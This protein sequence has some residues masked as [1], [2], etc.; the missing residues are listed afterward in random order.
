MT[1]KKKR[2]GNKNRRLKKKA[3]RAVGKFF[4]ILS[5]KSKRPALLFPPNTQH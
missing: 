5:L 4:L 2:R 3:S 1:E